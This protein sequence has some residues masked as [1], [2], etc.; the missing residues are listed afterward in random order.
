MRR[1][2]V[3][4]RRAAGTAAR[5]A[6]RS[7]LALLAQALVI[8]MAVA[9]PLLLH[10]CVQNLSRAAGQSGADPRITLFLVAGSNAEVA[11]ALAARLAAHAAVAGHRYVPRDEAL[12]ELRERHGL[13]DLSDLLPGNPL[14]DAFTVRARDLDPAALE[15]LRAEVAGWPGVAEAHLDAAWARQLQAGLA[16]ARALAFGIAAL[17]ALV[18]VASA[19]A[20]SALQA[21]RDREEIAVSRLLGASAT[22]VRRPFVY[23]ALAVGAAGGAIALGLSALCLRAAEGPL[24]AL[25]SLY[26]GQF[27][28]VGATPAES[29]TLVGGCALLAALGSWL[30]ATAH[31]RRADRAHA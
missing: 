13:P 4:C 29:V 18:L 12:V 10:L 25:V 31:L 17:L 1:W 28:L 7:P 6:A 2:L 20:V 5:R 27:A 30:A 3:H 8:G 16:F 14:P 23:L 19:F 21:S 9:L 15:A 11:Q 22:F 26:G 24:Q